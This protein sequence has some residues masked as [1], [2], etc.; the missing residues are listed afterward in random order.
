V[1]AIAELSRCDFSGPGGWFA[2]R[3]RTAG[4]PGPLQPASDLAPFSD[5]PCRRIADLGTL[6]P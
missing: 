4:I 2:N 1:A 5:I 6:F 3:K